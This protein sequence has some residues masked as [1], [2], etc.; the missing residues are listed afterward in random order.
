MYKKLAVILI[1]LIVCCAAGLGFMIIQNKQDIPKIGIKPAD[2]GAGVY[3]YN[4]NISS[5]NMQNCVSPAALELR[6]IYVRENDYVKKGD[7]LYLLDDSDIASAVSQALAGI[8]LAEVNLERALLAA[9]ATAQVNAK[10]AFDTASAAYDDARNNL[11]RM[12]ML[13]PLGGISQSDFE[14]AR[15]AVLAAEGQYN[16]A[17]I[18]YDTIDQISSLN[19]RSAEAQ[20][21]QA[22]AVYDAASANENKR[23]VSAEIDG[24]VADIWAHENNMLSPGQKILDIVDYGDLIIEI[25]VDQ[26]EI[27]AFRVQETVPVFINALNIT[28]NGTVSGISN[29]AVRTGEVSGFIVTINLE[30]NPALKI[31]LLAEVRKDV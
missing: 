25:I 14:K 31:G 4:G 9:G 3:I 20:L 18:N 23:R 7:L 24:V 26:F 22:R 30:K 10:S 13:E 11:D 17:K 21:A 28:V 1:V 15:T 29:Q 6:R 12:T 27:S 8:Q 2:T 5:N 19:V 16:Q